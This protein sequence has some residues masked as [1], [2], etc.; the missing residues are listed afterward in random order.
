[1]T[2]GDFYT[3]PQLAQALGID[4]TKLLGWIHRG[5]LQALNVA[6]SATGRPRWRIPADAWQAFQQARS[7][8]AQA[9]APRPQQRRRRRRQADSGI[10]QF[11]K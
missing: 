2:A 5:E 3:V 4:Q 6:E 10:I 9:P 7:N 8:T 11:Y 1:M